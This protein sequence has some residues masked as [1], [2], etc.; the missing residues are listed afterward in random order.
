MKK[1]NINLEISEEIANAERF[2][3]KF[4]TKFG[5]YPSVIIKNQVINI[6]PISITSLGELKA[7]FK[8]FLPK[9]F[10]KFVTLESDS[11]KREIV[12]LRYIYFKLGRQLGY[13]LES[14]GNSVNRDHSTV[15]N[16]LSQFKNMYE[17]DE[18]FRN[19]YKIIFNHIKSNYEPSIM[20][21]TDKMER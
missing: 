8:K 16:G 21:N 4:Y 7:H 10:E 14:L 5:Y 1:E 18:N 20:D 19:K 9:Y 12:D 13:T 11:K 2:M 17:T 3:Q 15:I 6:D